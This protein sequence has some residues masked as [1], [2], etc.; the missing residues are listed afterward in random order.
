MYRRP[1]LY[2]AIYSYRDY[3]RESAILR[4]IIEKN[5]KSS[6]N[7]LLDIA[8]GT[9][10]HLEFLQKDFECVGL[11]KSPHLL[12]MAEKRYPKCKFVE[13]DMMFFELGYWFDVV[14]CLFSAIGY[15]KNLEMLKSTVSR[16]FTHTAPG[17][18]VII[19]PWLFPSRFVEGHMSLDTVDRP[20]YKVSRMSA[21]HR[22]GD[23]C[24]LTYY[25]TVG[26]SG[27]VE[28]WENRSELALFT[29]LDYME[30][31]RQAGFEVEFDPVGLWSRGLLIGRKPL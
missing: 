27:K 10:H 5:K 11:D 1:D 22:A 2:D 30:A 25:F 24:V 16:F 12:K 7:R 19:E 14:I 13:A 8:C 3:E 17:G 29:E 31:M 6:G 9:A 20:N 21:S 23:V 4:E 18:V 28:T 15:T 26:R